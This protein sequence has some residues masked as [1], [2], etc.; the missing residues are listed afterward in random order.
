MMRKA[1]N[2]VEIA[3]IL[4]LVVVVS[5]AAM[6]MYNN[7]KLRVAN[8]ST[9][10]TTPVNLKTTK[11]SSDVLSK[12][13]PYDK[14][15]TAGTNA[16]TYLGVSEAKFNEAMSKLT[17]A[18]LKAAVTDKNNDIFTLANDLIS[19]LNLGYDKVSLESVTS[20]TLSTLTGVLNAAV[21]AINSDRITTP[22]KTVAKNYVT[23]VKSLLGLS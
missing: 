18:Q 14:T 20:S 13:V 1:V 8:L 3:L 17:Y 6:T 21:I 4:C 23:Q 7:Q 22:I 16:L 10:K 11:W 12:K 5:I 2:I 15:E 19:K 9:V